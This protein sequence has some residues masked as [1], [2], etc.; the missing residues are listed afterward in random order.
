ML[1]ENQNNCHVLFQVDFQCDVVLDSEPVKHEVRVF[2]VSAF[3]F[4]SEVLNR[5]SLFLSC[6]CCLAADEA[7][8]GEET[9]LSES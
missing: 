9:G 2:W 5:D 7:G 4:F 8:P 3:N 6:V 1:F